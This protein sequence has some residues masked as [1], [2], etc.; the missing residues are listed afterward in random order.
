MSIAIVNL[1]KDKRFKTLKVIGF[2]GTGNIPN[3]CVSNNPPTPIMFDDKE[4]EIVTFYF[5]VGQHVTDEIIPTFSLKYNTGC[6]DYVIQQSSSSI[7]KLE[8]VEE[9][10]G[11]KNVLI[12][13]RF[14]V[15][16]QKKEKCTGAPATHIDVNIKHPPGTGG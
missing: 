4:A 16:L 7:R 5:E 14:K 11:V 6:L 8:D 2:C 15:I 3:T 12:T 9:P 13:R 10:Q 1:C